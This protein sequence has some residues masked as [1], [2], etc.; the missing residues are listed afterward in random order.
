MSVFNVFLNIFLPI[1][2]FYLYQS[3]VYKRPQYKPVNTLRPNYDYV[4]VGG[5]S[6]GSVLAARLSENASTTV[7]LLEA[8]PSDIGNAELDTPIRVPDTFLSRFDWMFY[9]EPQKDSAMGLE[10]RRAYLP[11]GRVLGGSSQTNYMQWSR[12]HSRDYDRWAE[13]GA[14]GWSYLD[15]L[16]YFIRSEDVVP[17]ALANKDYRGTKGPMKITQL[18]GFPM[19]KAFIDAVKS[20]GYEERDYNGEHQEGVAH[21]QC[22]IYKGERWS[23][24]RA[25]LWPVSQRENLDIVTDAFVH[26]INIAKGRA[27]GVSFTRE[28]TAGT[29]EKVSKVKAKREVILSAGAF[30][31]PQLLMVSG[32]GPKDHLEEL[33]IPVMA[34]LPVGENLQDHVLTF[35][36][37]STNTSVGLP[38]I[39]LYHQMEYMF[40]GTGPLSSPGGNDG[41][42]YMKTSPGLQQPDVQLVHINAYLDKKFMKVMPGI[43]YELIQKW[44]ISPTGQGFLL[45]PTL[46]QPKSRG[47]LRLKTSNPLDYPAI[48]PAYLSDPEDIDTMVKAVKLTLKVINTKPF[49]E[50]G[51]RLD[52]SPLPGCESHTYNSD[53]Y[54][55]CYVLHLDLTSHH[56]SGTCKMGA[57]AD[58]STVVDTRLRVKG[59]EGLRVVDASIMP[60][61][62]SANTNAPTIMIAEKAADLITEDNK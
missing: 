47:R 4:I 40:F 3:Y 25:Y 13:M 17:K 29:E 30:G 39:S 10:G 53:E 11:R 58:P 48:D 57:S 5:G 33:K 12:G 41:I 43:T 22:N 6:A 36:L 31:S 16:P 52:Q 21:T 19:S 37:V 60:T 61:V 26:K 51:A 32:I 49:R 45:L 24:A 7:L 8:G 18:S 28:V 59:V 20:L 34:D 55:R 38:P 35:L 14:N 27:T 15:V 42:A 9:S 56:P 23:T 44:K 46:L 2:T 62:V 50:L 54:W 1:I